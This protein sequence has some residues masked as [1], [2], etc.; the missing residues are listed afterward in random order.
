MASTVAQFVKGC[1]LCQ[2][3]KINTHPTTPPLHPI[4]PQKDALPFQTITMDFITDLPSSN[5]FDALF[6]VVDH[7]VTKAVVLMPCTKQIDAIGTA[8][9]Y[10]NHVFRR[11]GLPKIMISDRGTQFASKVFQELC[12]KLGI[13]S[14][15]STAYHPQTDG[16]TE[17]INQEVE[18]Y[19]RI[20]CSTHPHTWSEHL[21]NI[22]FAHNILPHSNTQMAPFKLLLGYEPRSIP[23]QSPSSDSPAV[24]QRLAKLVH[25][26]KEALAAHALA[27]MHMSR[28]N[29][30][31]FTPFN[32]GDAVWLEATYLRAPGRSKKLAP[33]REGPFKIKHKISDLVYEL[34]LPEQWKIHPVFHASLLSP[35][36][37]T[38]E[39]GPSFSAPPP[40][41]IEGEEEYEI[42]GIVAH[43][44]QGARRKYLVKWLGYPTS[45]NQ[46]LPL[47]ELTRNAQDILNSYNSQH[48]L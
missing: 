13:K 32:E 17:R 33:K 30:R 20:Y 10:H 45:E 9:L 24:Q 5:N 15:L 22:E 18:A 37:E 47:K 28:H 38:I 35:F 40:D 43:K 44:G 27:A 25:L 14:K 8:E 3:M 1:A 11:F 48:N 16:Q 39:H 2:Q 4:P 26:R 12:A 46:W 29:T 23:D 41:I 36:T 7:D 6:I 42:E 19:L 34:Q 21:T 31:N